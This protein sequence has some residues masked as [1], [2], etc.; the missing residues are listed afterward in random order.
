MK[1]YYNLSKVLCGVF[2]ILF[3][4]NT[5]QAQ[6]VNPDLAKKRSLLHKYVIPGISMFVSGTL[7]GTIEAI[8]FHYDE[9]FK[10]VFPKANDQYWNPAI[11]WT[12]KYRNNNPSAGPKYPGSTSFL[13]STTDAY[14]ALR[15][16]RNLTDAFTLSFYIGHSYRETDRPTLKKFLIN[17]L[18]LT[19][20][21]NVGFYA[22]YSWIFY[23]TGHP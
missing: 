22:T 3:C 8:S 12:N 21:R 4:I 11:S 7:D 18:V 20:I 10:R 1:K 2:A 5:M 17:A 6:N 16:A 23:E 9:G 19:A 15:T 14:H 13:V